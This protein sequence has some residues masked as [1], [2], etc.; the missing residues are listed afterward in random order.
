MKIAVFGTPPFAAEIFERLRL[1]DELEVVA[2]ITTEPKPRGRGKAVTKTAVSSWAE[3]NK[4][5]V[6]EPTK[7]S[8]ELADA[9]HKLEAEV[10]V[11][12]AYGHI[13]RKDFLDSAPPAWNLHFSL[14]PKYRGSSPVQTA[15]LSGDPVSGTT[16][17]R[18]C[19]GMDD[20]PVLGETETN[21]KNLR[22]DTVFEKLIESG[23]VLLI[24]LLKK[25]ANNEKLI[26]KEQN[27]TAAT[28]CKKINK[29][30]GL[31]DPIQET[32]ECAYRK[33]LAFYPWPG[34]WI[35]HNGKRLKI[36][37]ASIAPEKT[38]PGQLQVA[39]NRLLLGFSDSVSLEL[40]Q[41]QAEGKKP[42][43]G[44]DYARG[45]GVS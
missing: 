20:G 29:Q 21:I 4:I 5:R 19:P 45:A 39:D 33:V 32:A 22:A 10:C 9:L 6:F 17:F 37:D 24:D 16:V 27:H 8:V 3:Q 14:L 35:E 42:V 30:D 26:E 15:I 40:S 43:T 25:R 34:T 41:V 7:P 13:F 38:N 2:A 36:L 28:F 31:I 44:M 11:V 1:F 12:I 23:T 18:I